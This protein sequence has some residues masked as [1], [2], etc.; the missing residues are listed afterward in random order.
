MERASAALWLCV[1]VGVAGCGTESA[2]ER[3]VLVRRDPEPAGAHC[4]HGGTA[5]HA[6]TDTDGDG[7]LDDSEIERSEYVCET[8]STLTR[9]DPIEPGAECPNGGDAVHVGIDD[10]GD[11]ILQDSEIDATTYACDPSQVWE[12]DFGELDWQDQAK[13]AALRAARVVTGS[14]TIAGSTGVSLPR[15][16]LVG[17]GLSVY[18]P[19]PTLDLPALRQVSGSVEID[20]PG[21]DELALPALERVLGE[22]F[23]T[24]NGV[25][26]VSIEAPHLAEIGGRFVL[27]WGARG[28]VTMPL[29]AHIGAGLKIA[30]RLTGVHLGGLVSITGGLELDDRALIDLELPALA[31]IT[32]DVYAYGARPLANISLPAMTQIGGTLDLLDVSALVSVSIPQLT[33][34]G[35]DLSIHRAP[36]LETLALGG[37]TTVD[38]RVLISDVPAL[39]TVSLGSLASVGSVANISIQIA[40]TGLTMLDLP[41]L[42]TATG[43]IQ[44]LSSSALLEVRLPHLTHADAL[45]IYD[46]L[47]LH[48]VRAP[49]VTQLRSLSS[50][51]S[52]ALATVDFAALSIVDTLDLRDAALSSLS[53]LHALTRARAI[54]IRHLDH[55][56]SLS[57]L[58]ALG[59]LSSLEVVSNAALTSLDG[60][61]GVTRLLGSLRFSTLPALTSVA[62]LRN[63]QRIGGDAE[64]SFAPLLA[65]PALPKLVAVDGAFTLVGLG[66]VTTLAGFGALQL[67]G[68]QLVLSLPQV[69]AAEI[70]AFRQRLGK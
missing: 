20:V 29:L 52:P 67:V 34:I 51:L 41:A 66:P 7:V 15:L 55:L 27:W 49:L 19:L 50:A 36:L 2:A 63:L 56:T 42:A 3:E 64:L 65:V 37:L 57:G 33:H 53:G 23:V 6:G 61:E 9:R 43:P 14:L 70:A 69:P 18:G 48:T 60:L 54:Y 40:R 47:S 24:G 45:D 26:G 12:G 1:L 16:E 62:G 46:D 13:V 59:S 17:A 28:E 35:G 25:H 21:I 32:G 44:I 11:G 22:V 30:G 39:A 4:E 8:A 10:N 68:G 5:I 58:S 38:S 31:Q